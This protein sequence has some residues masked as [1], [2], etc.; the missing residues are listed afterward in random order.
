[1]HGFRWAGEVSGF[2]WVGEVSGFRCAGEVSGFRSCPRKSSKS[3]QSSQPN[4]FCPIQTNHVSQKKKH[5]QGG[6]SGVVLVVGGVD[7][8]GNLQN[9]YERFLHLRMGWHVSK[10]YL[11]SLLGR[12]TACT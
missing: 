11:T 4:E 2:R 5:H 3:I 1:M 12:N 7:K 6:M 9:R 8:F 10:P